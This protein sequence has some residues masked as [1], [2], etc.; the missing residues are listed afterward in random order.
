MNLFFLP[1]RIAALLISGGRQGRR[2]LRYIQAILD[3]E[4]VIPGGIAQLMAELDC[5]GDTAPEIDDKHF[6][7]ADPFVSTEGI[8]AVDIALEAW[9]IT[10]ATDFLAAMVPPMEPA[11]PDEGIKWAAKN[12]DA[13][14]VNSLVISG[15]IVNV[16]DELCIIV[17]IG[18]AYQREAF[19]YSKHNK[20]MRSCRILAKP[21][22]AVP[23]A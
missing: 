19:L 22:K 23:V 4:T 20:F 13:Q 18:N 6:P 14:R 3:G 12:P 9:S 7:G 16:G 2:T 8:V 5:D 17:L 21:K 11:M 1:F 15:R 10:M